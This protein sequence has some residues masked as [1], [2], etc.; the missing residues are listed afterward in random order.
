[1]SF[2]DPYIS[3]IE[4]LSLLHGVGIALGDGD[5]GQVA[6]EDLSIRVE[7]A[8]DLIEVIGFSCF[9]DATAY[10]FCHLNELL[11]SISIGDPVEIVHGRHIVLYLGVG[12]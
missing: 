3:A 7:V 6:G 5:I 8:D 9:H 4:I 10:G 12:T 11:I 2:N 1:M